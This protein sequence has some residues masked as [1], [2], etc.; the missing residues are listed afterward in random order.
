MSF[1]LDRKGNLSIIRIAI[2]IGAVGL[3]VIV[4][5]FALYSIEASTYQSPLN[6]DP[7]PSAVQW[8][9]PT[10]GPGARR[11]TY[12]QVPDMTPEEVAAYYQEKLDEHYDNK[13]TDY[14][15]ELCV[16]RPPGDINFQAYEEGQGTLPYLYT[17]VFDR[18]GFRTLQ[19]TEIR[20]EPGILHPDGTDTRG[21]T[22]VEYKQTWEE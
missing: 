17:C 1:L 3:I 15:R 21:V 16:R 14:D 10:N 8:G 13:P 22:V 6:I 7:P 2:L 20:I 19:T 18:A 9:E 12:Y 11:V 5:G 4:A